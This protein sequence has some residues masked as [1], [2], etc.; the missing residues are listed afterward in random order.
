MA[1]AGQLRAAVEAHVAAVGA[2]D[3]GALPA[4]YAPDDRL[5]D[6]A[7]G[8]PLMGRA[9][10]ADHFA[11]VP[12]DPRAL[13]IMTIAVTGHDAAVHLR[14]APAGSRPPTSSTP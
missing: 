5:Y 13:Q 3:A 14:A 11:R 10:V 12:S 2:A 1:S 9:A 8:Q 6:P 4:L 7:G